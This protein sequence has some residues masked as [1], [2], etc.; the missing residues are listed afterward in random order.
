MFSSNSLTE[1]QISKIKAWAEEGDALADIQRKMNAEMEIKVT[2]L[3]TR[4]MLEDLKIELKPEPEP[5]KNEDEEDET[6]GEILLDDTEATGGPEGD[7]A[8]V[9]IDKVQRPGALVSGKVTFA[10]GASASWWLDQMGQLGMD[11]DTE[12]FKPNEAQMMSFQKELQ[13]AIQQSGI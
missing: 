13:A 12:G 3:E 8:S 11:P 4:F 7:D 10:G 2:Y 6:E 5:E 1:D 9:A